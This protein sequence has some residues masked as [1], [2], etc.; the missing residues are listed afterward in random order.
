MFHG[1]QK[2][3]GL[4]T[5]QG[6]LEGALVALTGQEI[7]VF[8][9]GRTDTGAHAVGQA[10][11]F[12]M[13][14]EVDTSRT[15]VSLNA[16]LPEGVAVTTMRPAPDGFDP[17]RDAL[18]RE[19]RYF[20]LNRVAPSALLDEFTYHFPRELDV[21]LMNKACGSFVGGHDFSAF[22]AKSPDE[23]SVRNVMECDTVEIFEGLVSMRVRADSFLYRMVRIMAGAVVSVGS[24]KMTLEE[25]VTCID[26][27]ATRP[28]SDPL[29]AR[30]LFL[31]QVSYQKDAGR[32]GDNLIM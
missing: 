12:D 24:G 9:A 17:R 26:G 14:S 15:L 31:W 25:L 20:I 11:A 8:G 3:P 18:W 13:P 21:G 22:R 5:I 27:P 30:G 29:P 2:Q 32:P 7:R 1:F 16:L 6:A 28:C 4:L 23:S 10:A 19:Y